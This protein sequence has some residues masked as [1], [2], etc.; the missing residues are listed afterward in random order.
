MLYWTTVVTT[1]F[2][3]VYTK[4][5]TLASLVCTPSGFPY[6]TC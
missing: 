4:T 5:S 2:K 1:S 6:S 3:T